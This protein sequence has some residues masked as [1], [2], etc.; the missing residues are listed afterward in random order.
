MDEERRASACVACRECEAEY[1]Q[2]IAISEWL[3]YVHEVLGEGREYVAGEAPVQALSDCR[4]QDQST[5]GS[6]GEP[7]GDPNAALQGAAP[8]GA[9]PA[10]PDAESVASH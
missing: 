4:C 10:V 2:H 3:S 1:P 5:V 6:D 8:C 9:S 7:Q